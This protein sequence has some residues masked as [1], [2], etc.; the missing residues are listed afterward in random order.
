MDPATVAE[1]AR[2]GSGPCPSDSAARHEVMLAPLTTLRCGGPAAHLVDVASET[3][4]IE[5]V[6]A[7]DAAGEPVLLLGRGSNLVVADEGYPGTAIRVATRGFELRFDEEFAYV[8]AA[9]GE[10]WDLVV[11]HA[12]SEGLVGIEAM[13]GIPGTV[14]AAPVQNIGAYGAEIASTINHITAYD[15]KQRRVRRFD[16]QECGFGYRDSRFKREPDRWV[17][18]AVELRLLRGQSGGVVHYA[19]LADRLDVNTGDR[20][21]AGLIRRAVLSLRRERGMVLDID[22]RDTWSVGSFFV[23]PV[24]SESRGRTLP[25][26]APQWPAPGGVKISAAWLI[27]QAGF[28]KG[29]TLRPGAPAAI[30]TKHALALTNQADATTADILELA[31]AIRAAVGSKFEIELTPEPTLVG[32]EL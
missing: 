26:D 13:A 16:A 5:A 6:A 9:A 21:E 7:G 17:V 22:D 23:N 32:C 15:R 11:A 2:T 4:L 20:V 8:S 3:A 28:S 19:A 25:E 1:P 31:R 10:P 30:S 12:V 18:L 27:E 29:D 14:G 24:V